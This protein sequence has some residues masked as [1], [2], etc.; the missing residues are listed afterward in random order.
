[1]DKKIGPKDARKGD[2]TLAESKDLFEESTEGEL[3]VLPK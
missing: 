3:S 2:M 1:M